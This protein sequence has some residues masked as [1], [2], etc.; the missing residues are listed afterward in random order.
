L[1]MIPH[2]QAATRY[3]PK[4]GLNATINPATISMAPTI[5]INVAAAMPVQFG[6]TGARY[7]IQSVK[8]L[9]YLSRP[10]TIGATTNAM[11]RII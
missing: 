9:K 8:T 5:I 6:T 7:R 11:S 10:A 2:S 1:M 4:L 3:P